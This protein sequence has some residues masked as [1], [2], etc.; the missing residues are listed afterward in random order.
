MNI[1][2]RLMN[3][4]AACVA[5]F[6]MFAGSVR[7]DDVPECN[8]LPALDLPF[9]FAELLN[10]GSGWVWTVDAEGNTNEL[11]GHWE[12]SPCD[13]TMIVSLEGSTIVIDLSRPRPMGCA[14]Y[15]FRY[16][17]SLDAGIVTEGEISV[18]D[19]GMYDGEV[20][21]QFGS[22]SDGN[23]VKIRFTNGC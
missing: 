19:W 4:T 22:M 10:S 21:V 14:V 3:L 11:L 1:S 2:L 9:E 18:P 17:L 5:A 12:L 20:D 7:A 8:I 6:T 23:S 15:G 13:Q 16:T